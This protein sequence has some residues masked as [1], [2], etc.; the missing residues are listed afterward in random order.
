VA[1][2]PYYKESDVKYGR[3][4]IRIAS[5]PA[6]F[7]L[8]DTSGWTVRRFLKEL[9]KR[10][11]EHYWKEKK[12][13]WNEPV[14]TFERQID[15]DPGEKQQPVKKDRWHTPKENPPRPLPVSFHPLLWNEPVK[16]GRWHTS[17]GKPPWHIPAN[18]EPLSDPDEI[19]KFL[20]RPPSV[21]QI[22]SAEE[23]KEVLSAG[24]VLIAVD[25]NTPDLKTRLQLEATKIRK[26]HPLSI[27]RGRG[28]PSKSSDIAGVGAETLK[29]WRA[30]RIIELHELRLEGYDPQK[31]RKQ[32]AAWLFPEQR[33]QRKRGE[34]LDGAVRLLNEA[35]ASARIID[36]QTR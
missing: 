9:M 21:G 23:A 12:A 22:E 33:D 13:S 25:P 14:Q 19:N 2:R 8:Y 34:M 10:Q 1:R 5:P 17:E 26:A 18:F 35:L 24:M 16:K 32:V 20:C 4:K 27:Q 28:R 3:R 31:E 15:H 7:Q 30:Y 11:I 36:A 6:F 29:Q